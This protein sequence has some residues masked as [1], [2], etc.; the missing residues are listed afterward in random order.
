[1]VPARSVPQGFSAMFAFD[2]ALSLEANAA[3]MTEALSAVHDGEVTVAVRDS[4]AADGTPIATGDVIGIVDDKIRFVGSDVT[5]VA[6]R[7]VCAMQDEF[8]GDTLTVLRGSDLAQGDF[9]ALVASLEER[10]PDLEVDAQYGGQPLY[11][12]VLSV[13]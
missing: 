6:E 4:Q 1:V 9:D 2:P 5:E 7:M 3:A 12:V 13:E 8:E 11:P 10:L